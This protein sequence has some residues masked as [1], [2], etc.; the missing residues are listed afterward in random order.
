MEDK[1]QPPIGPEHGRLLTQGM[2]FLGVASQFGLTLLVLG[3]V[4]SLLD[5][6][7]GWAP[8][9]LLCGILLGMAAG[10]YSMLKQLE[11]LD[12]MK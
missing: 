12:K 10:L 9:G 11:K 5:E 8:W 4:G 1:P 2:R 7:Y 3:Y 6:R